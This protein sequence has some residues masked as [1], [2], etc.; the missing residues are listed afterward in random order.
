V[1]E[2]S[3]V[4]PGRPVNVQSRRQRPNEPELARR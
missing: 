1:H 4:S 2:G 3:V